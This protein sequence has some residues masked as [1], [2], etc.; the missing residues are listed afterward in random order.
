M[1]YSQPTPDHGDQRLVSTRRGRDESVQTGSPS[2]AHLAGSAAAQTQCRGHSFT[3][4]SRCSEHRAWKKKEVLRPCAEAQWTSVR[5]WQAAGLPEAPLLNTR[6]PCGGSWTIGGVCLFRLLLWVLCLSLTRLLQ[7]FLAVQQSGLCL[8]LL[9]AGVCPWE[10]EPRFHRPQCGQNES[11][12]RAPE[13]WL[14]AIP[15]PRIQATPLRPGSFCFS[16]NR[17]WT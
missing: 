13:K 5:S 12:L 6:W 4:L 11:L 3:L 1:R 7:E 15:G 17:E 2:P 14:L 16:V 10:R 9:G 8:S